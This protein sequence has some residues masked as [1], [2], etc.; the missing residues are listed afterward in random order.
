MIGRLL[1]G[2]YE[3]VERVGTG[4]MAIVYRARC[5]LLHRDVAV[6]VLKEEHTQDEDFL[7][8]FRQEARAAASLSHPNVVSI[9][10]VGE[11]RGL[12]YIVMEYIDGPTL[13]EWIS[14]KG[15]LPVDE[16]LEITQQVLS[17]L[18]HAHSHG[19]IHRDIKPHNILL[20]SS[21]MWKV[22]DFGIARATSGS[23]LKHTQKILGSA[24]YFSPEQAR[25]GYVGERA[26]LYATGV[27]LYE[28]LT[29]RVPFEGDSPVAIALK[30]ISEPV[31]AISEY[32]PDIPSALEAAIMKAM[33]KD[34]D[35]RYGSA[36]EM[37]E[38]L[39]Q[40]LQGI[41]PE[42]E[43]GSDC[44][45]VAVPRV[46]RG[47][48]R[49]AANG[50]GKEGVGSSSNR[51]NRQKESGGGGRW[52][53]VLAWVAALA[54]LGGTFAY[55]GYR[56]WEWLDV[57]VVQ[58]PFVEGRSLE[59]AQRLLE[60]A[61]LTGRIAGQ[62]H[63]DAIPVGHIIQQEPTAGEDVRKNRVVDLIMSMGPEWIDDG[64]PNVGDL[65]VQEAEAT[66]YNA[67]LEVELV[68]RYDEDVRESYIVDQNPSPGTR[69]QKGTTVTLVVSMG[70]EP[71]P[72]SLAGFIGQPLDDA[73]TRISDLGLRLRIV[74][75]FTEYP[76]GIVADQNPDPGSTVQ[77]GDT[78]VLVVSKG[79]ED[80]NV[81]EITISVPDSPPEQEILVRV[82]DKR[83]E[84]T[85][86][87]NSHDAGDVIAMN[88]YW[89]DDTARVRVF[90][91]GLEV[92]SKILKVED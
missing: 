24:H 45:T 74:E 88:V 17:A 47:A 59:D 43:G 42:E 27:V 49:N 92:M 57:P 31:P 1:G 19:V 40:G 81:R 41:A 77:R 75:E 64:V 54:I 61:A 73:R 60:S 53:L 9:H 39:R 37:G 15:P 38:A 26:D 76:D 35:R 51:N 82:V 29:R 89:Y 78:V 72:F 63:D 32:N 8:R 14:E 79:E 85:V 34:R 55:G 87:R 2:R 7:S 18:D 3:V 30:H 90:S 48:H 62:R 20:S 13:K 23:T 70:P 22:A 83:G 84:R 44:P 68:E 65:H 5:S 25:G 12:P 56:I 4:G 67:G 80:A 50:G 21:G 10:D 86:Y 6:K 11:E 52:K 46:R 71:A 33:H 91:N 66:L 69:V 28:M 36:K 16:A 58:V